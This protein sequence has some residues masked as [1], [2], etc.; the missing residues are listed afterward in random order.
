MKSLFTGIFL[1]MLTHLAFGQSDFRA[2]YVITLERDTLFG[3]VDYKESA[4][5]S[6]KCRFID[7]N[8]SMTNDFNPKEI[9]GYGFNQDKFF[10]S[11]EV[12]KENNEV[13]RVFIQVLV[14]GQASL[15]RYKDDFYLEK[16]E[17]GLLRLTDPKVL[18]EKNGRKYY[19]KPIK[20]IGIFNSLLT[21]CK[22]SISKFDKV[23]V[24][25]KSFTEVVES[26]NECTG[27][28]YIAYKE[29]KPWT[30]TQ[31]G[32]VFGY[33]ASQ[34][35]MV[36]R[37]SYESHLD[38]SSYTNFSP[39]LGLSFKFL[40]PR[41]N[42]K[43]GITIDLIGRNQ[44]YKVFSGQRDVLNSTNSYMTLSFFELKI[45]Y[46]LTYTLTGKKTSP[47][48]SGGASHTLHFNRHSEAIYENNQAGVVYTSRGHGQEINDF[49]MGIW[50][51]L[52]VIR[53][54]SSRYSG[55][56][57]FRAEKTN[58]LNSQKSGPGLDISPSVNNFQ[59][60]TGIYFK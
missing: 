10:E 7:Y 5:N 58:G 23:E 6:K 9:F 45:P 4:L 42:E 16:E 28:P 32:L 1:L 20:H 11:K 60:L 43:L 29:E 2:G 59:I 36:S 14:K 12:V 13:D 33:N 53:K 21:D 17:S 54:M 57:E 46:G 52:G 30:V 18:V 24:D 47:F 8:N 31:I 3:L 19:R 15:Y 49:Q 56:V 25:E 51:S 22:Y 44:L 34:A 55:F 39:G 26:Y 35:N 50:A 38:G 37:L 27:L 48:F 41:I 40:A